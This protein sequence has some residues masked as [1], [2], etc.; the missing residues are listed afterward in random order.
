MLCYIFG[1]FSGLPMSREAR[2]APLVSRVNDLS[3]NEPEWVQR[4]LAGG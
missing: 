4:F 1:G 2:E 3:K